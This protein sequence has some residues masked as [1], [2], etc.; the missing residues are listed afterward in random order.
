MVKTMGSKLQ[1]VTSFEGVAAETAGALTLYF[2]GHFSA[3][4]HNTYDYR[5]SIGVGLT[6][7]RSLRYAGNDGFDLGLGS[8]NTNFGNSSF[9][10]YYFLNILMKN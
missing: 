7:K 4:K 9:T 1:K 3:S 5:I 8:Y 2:T 6:K 10:I